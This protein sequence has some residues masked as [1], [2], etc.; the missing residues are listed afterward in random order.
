MCTLEDLKNKVM[1]NDNPTIW[2]MDMFEED[3]GKAFGVN[4]V[5]VDDD[6]DIILKIDTELLVD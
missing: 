5:I 1:G 2:V 6:G 3:T 4:E